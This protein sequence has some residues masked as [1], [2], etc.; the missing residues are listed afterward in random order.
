MDREAAEM[1][2]GVI[3]MMGVAVLN[4]ILSSAGFGLQQLDVVKELSVDLFEKHRPE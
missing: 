3:N 1:W 4:W 2:F